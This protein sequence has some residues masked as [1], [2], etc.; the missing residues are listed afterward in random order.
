[1]DRQSAA[2]QDSHSAGF[3]RARATWVVA[4][5]FVC[6]TVFVLAAAVVVSPGFVAKH[7]SRDGI[8]EG[9]TV[10]R[11]QFLRICAAAAAAT[12]AYC[13]VLALVV[14]SRAHRT[15][16]VEARHTGIWWRP[17][18][19]GIPGA[20]WLLKKWDAGILLGIMIF[21]GIL[22]FY[23]LHVSSS[24]LNADCAV[25]NEQV[26]TLD[27]RG[28]TV[29]FGYFA[30]GIIFTRLM[31]WVNINLA[32][33]L[34]ACL[35]GAMGVTAIY[36][37]VRYLTGNTL[38]GFMS[39][40]ILGFANDYMCHS[41]FSEVHAA[42]T[43]LATVALLAWFLGRP[44]LAGRLF[45]WDMLVTPL[46]VV[47]LPTFLGRRLFRKELSA[48]AAACVPGYMVFLIVFWRD[49]FYGPRGLLHL[50]L[51]VRGLEEIIDGYRLAR[52]LFGTS[53]GLSAWLGLFGVLYAVFSRST[54][55]R[56]F[57]LSAIVTVCL[58][59]TVCGYIPQRGFNVLVYP[60]VAAAAGIG[61]HALSKIP[62]RARGVVLGAAVLAAIYSA[63]SSY[64]AL[65]P[66][67]DSVETE[68]QTYDRLASVDK[69]R[70]FTTD[71]WDVRMMF[72]WTAF[73]R[74]HTEFFI[75]PQR[76][77]F[78]TIV[79]GIVCFGEPFWVLFRD[80][81]YLVDRILSA[82]PDFRADEGRIGAFK[83]WRITREASLPK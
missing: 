64:R 9:I 42:Q 52:E 51:G 2:S 16:D 66:Y 61:F 41:L 31:P 76:P 25:Y 54:H 18:V 21:L 38:A 82:H 40:F 11:I 30:L 8:L 1:M 24:L 55:L 59:L 75:D 19:H 83:W 48:A 4:L 44:G 6:A 70:W 13:T 65:R 17:L 67:L 78:D 43:G 20:R 7:L 74:T 63:T 47:I 5:A 46:S 23:V 69:A 27:L 77:D 79:A 80:D 81:R 60:M 3:R 32:M 53:F 36:A 45:L 15:Q 62:T 72:E 37:L 22:A 58:H 71:L 14:A 56:R 73:G 33:N 12:L 50:N 28:R 57:I 34:M 35:C 68:Q 26:A 49:Y 10:L 39:A 29:H